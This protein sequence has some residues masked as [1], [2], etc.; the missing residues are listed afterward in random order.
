[1]T[2]IKTFSG[3]GY[4][5][6]VFAKKA[7]GLDLKTLNI[8]I[9]FLKILESSFEQF[10]ISF[11]CFKRYFTSWTWSFFWQDTKY[12]SWDTR[13]IVAGT[14]GRSLSFFGVRPAHIVSV[15]QP[16]LQA[17]CFDSIIWSEPCHKFSTS[18]DSDDVVIYS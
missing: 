1:M 5:L 7:F 15:E 2:T 11:N 12:D 8:A 9:F 17:H 14:F 18:S 16:I 13:E 6:K 3:K 4:D 10:D